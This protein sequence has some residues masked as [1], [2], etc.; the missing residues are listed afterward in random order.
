[1][2]LVAGSWSPPAPEEPRNVSGRSRQA[3]RGTRTRDPFPTREVLYRLSYNRVAITENMLR[4]AAS[5]INDIRRL[6]SLGRQLI[7][8]RPATYA[9]LDWSCDWFSLTQLRWSRLRA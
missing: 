3:V 7:Q 2:G 4:D 1:M 5:Q 8:P 6:I 9:R